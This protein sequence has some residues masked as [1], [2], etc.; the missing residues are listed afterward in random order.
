MSDCGAG[1]LATDSEVFVRR[2]TLRENWAFWS[3]AAV[4]A[5][6]SAGLTKIT[7]V[8]S[9]IEAN[10]AGSISGGAIYGDGVALHL[11]RTAFIGNSAVQSAGAIFLINSAVSWDL[12]SAVLIFLEH[13]AYGQL[14]DQLCS[15]NARNRLW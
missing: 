5:H 6:V 2:C 13:P 8:D 9:E 7:I 10:S 4:Y 11:E 15:T 14:N 12:Y 1:I 3:G